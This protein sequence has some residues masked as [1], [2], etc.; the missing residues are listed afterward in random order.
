MKHTTV[1]R[2]LA[3]TVGIMLVAGA[4]GSSSSDD[5]TAPAPSAAEG[6]LVDEG[7]PVDGGTVTWGLEAETD[8]LNPISGRFAMSGHMM[9][10]A[11]FDPLATIDEDGNA[12]PYLAEALTP[13]DE[14]TEWTITLRPDVTFHDGTPLTA[15]VV[16]D[17]YRL[18]KDS[19]I[20]AR[21][22]ADIDTIEVSGPLEVTMTMKMPWASFPYVLTTQ[23]GYIPAPSM[24]QTAEQA[25]TP[26]G[27][28]PFEFQS[29]DYETSFKANKYAG[30]WQPGKPHLDSIEFRPIPDAQQRRNDL[31]N[32]DIDAMNTF[33]PSDIS[34]IAGTPGFKV[35]TYDEGEERFIMLNSGVEP[36]T[37]KTAR[38]A[39]AYAT[40]SARVRDEV[41]GTGSVVPTAGIWAPG[42]LGYRDD[43]GYPGFDLERAK[44]LAAQYKAE[45]G[46]D[47]S[48]TLTSADDIDSQR[49]QQLLVEMWRAAGMQVELKTVTQ[50]DLVVVG[51]LGTYQ[52]ADWRNFG[53]PDPDGEFVWLHSRNIDP[54]FISLNFAQFAD[55]GVDAALERGHGTLDPIVRDEAYA[56]VAQIL[57]DNTP[58]I[59][60]YRVTWAIASTD[61]VHGYGAAANGT[62]QTVGTKTW[63]ADLWRS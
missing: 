25:R 8:G 37:S 2:M 5:T 18:H 39:V 47:L 14:F 42:Q 46:K 36:F 49:V 40:D 1:G 15:E 52:A 34:E 17:T 28:G 57:N 58:Y 20:T 11:I 7:T 10:S 50:A 32:G 23:A 54:S 48:F 12:V 6:Q 30:Y 27:T 38:Q 59:W 24:L 33:R 26:S 21:A 43:T 41:F 44:E 60:L 56:E 3:A 51:A 45:T 62:L 35:L 63:V 16:A 4:C 22:V 55:P 31:L 13:N 53:Q 29:W 9:A 61:E 19:A